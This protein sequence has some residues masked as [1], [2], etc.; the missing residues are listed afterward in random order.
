MKHYSLIYSIHHF[1]SPR[2]SKDFRNHADFI[3]Y[4]AFMGFLETAAK[5][6]RDFDVMLEA[7]SKDTALLKL[8]DQLASS[9]IIKRI[10][11]GEFV[12]ILN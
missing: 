12:Y 11:N 3:D 6:N 2:N 4:N 5:V 10:N 1:S 8:S 9:A 7:K